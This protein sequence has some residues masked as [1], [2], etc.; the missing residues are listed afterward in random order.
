MVP[1]GH[2]RRAAVLRYRRVATIVR[3][4][5]IVNGL[6]LAAGLLHRTIQDRVI[7]P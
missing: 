3:F 6:K 5:P 1:V 7:S 2:Y 4:I